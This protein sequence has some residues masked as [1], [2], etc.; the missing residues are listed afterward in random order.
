MLMCG[1]RD[2]EVIHA[3]IPDSEEGLCSLVTEPTQALPGLVM[4]HNSRTGRT[5]ERERGRE[6]ENNS[7]ILFDGRFLHDVCFS[8]LHTC[9]HTR[10]RRRV[11]FISYRTNPGSAWSC[12]DPY[13]YLISLSH[14]GIS[15]RYLISRY[16][17]IYLMVV[18]YTD[19]HVLCV[20]RDLLM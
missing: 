12:G 13:R 4:I 1:S 18:S 3:P 17:I 5:G 16:V 11:V 14:T 10:L 15:S 8:G 2:F 7:Y 19:N 20:S 9:A 6:G